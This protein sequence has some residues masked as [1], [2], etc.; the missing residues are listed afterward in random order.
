M[1]TER[2]EAAEITT[3]KRSPRRTNGEDR[4]VTVRPRLARPPQAGAGAGTIRASPFRLRY[5]RFSVVNP[6]ASVTSVRAL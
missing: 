5:L 6:V 1:M 4:Q 2:T 3:E